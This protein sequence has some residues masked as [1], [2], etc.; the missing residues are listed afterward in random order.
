VTEVED[1]EIVALDTILSGPNGELESKLNAAAHYATRLSADVESS[2]L[3]HVF[4]NGKHFDLDD[5]GS[6]HPC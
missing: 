5:V 4:V 3:G 2:P 6:F 1:L